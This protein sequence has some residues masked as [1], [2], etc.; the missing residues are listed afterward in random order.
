MTVEQEFWDPMNALLLV[1]ILCETFLRLALAMLKAAVRPHCSF[2]T[3]SG[4]GLVLTPSLEEMKIGVLQK[5]TD[6]LT[7]SVMSEQKNKNAEHGFVLLNSVRWI[8][9]VW[10]AGTQGCKQTGMCM[11]F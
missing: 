4:W 11:L 1:R 6:V 9:L 10:S 8:F 3:S 5:G 7:W 2:R